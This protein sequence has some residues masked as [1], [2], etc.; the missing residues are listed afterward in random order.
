M[1]A[2]KHIAA[3]CVMGFAIGAVSLGAGPILMTYFALATDDTP[4]KVALGRV[5]NVSPLHASDCAPYY[6]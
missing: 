3:G 2:G 1:V 6:K 5:V 4:Q